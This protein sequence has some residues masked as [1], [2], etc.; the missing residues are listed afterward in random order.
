MFETVLSFIF[1]FFGQYTTQLFAAFLLFI[2]RFKR[3]PYFCLRM[4]PSAAFYLSLP[5]WMGYDRLI[6]GWLNFTFILEFVLVSALMVFCFSLTW[7][8]MLFLRQLHTQCRTV[9]IT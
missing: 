5:Y 6:V 9:W 8:Q 4:V 7:R 2:V 3:R 1:A